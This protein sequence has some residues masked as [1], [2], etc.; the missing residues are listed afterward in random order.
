L[1]TEQFLPPSDLQLWET[2]AE[3]Y[4]WSEILVCCLWEEMSKQIIV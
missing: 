1:T 2:M 4:N 3:H